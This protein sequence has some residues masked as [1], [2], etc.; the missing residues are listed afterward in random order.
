MKHFWVVLLLK[1]LAK[2]KL[3]VLRWVHKRIY[4]VE[5]YIVWQSWPIRPQLPSFH[6]F[7][8]VSHHTFRQQL[9]SDF[10]SFVDFVR[11]LLWLSI[12]SSISSNINNI[13][14][15]SVAVFF[16]IYTFVEFLECT[17]DWSNINLNIVYIYI[18]IYHCR[19]LDVF[20]A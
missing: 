8:L 2:K 12:Q 15:V 11:R 20:I 10:S 5:N 18:Y 3:F 17:D 19:G 6:V 13:A 4:C 7:F 14:N 9:S 16:T 1:S